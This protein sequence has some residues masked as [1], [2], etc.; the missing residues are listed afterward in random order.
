MT[1]SIPDTIQTIT[2]EILRKMGILFD[3]VIVSQ[4]DD[5]TY[6]INILS[7]DASLLIGHFGDTLKALQ[8]IIKAIIGDKHLT[9]EPLF[10][11]CDVEGYKERQEEKVIEMAKRAIEKVHSTG[12]A[13]HLPAMSPYFRKVVHMFLKEYAKEGI[14]SHSEGE[15]DDRHIVVGKE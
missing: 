4:R 8:Y 1:P 7:E 11:I 3:K 2:E 14:T 9:G 10:I 6:R 13:Q 5:V 15:G 12:K